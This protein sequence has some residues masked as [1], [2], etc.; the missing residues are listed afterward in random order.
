MKNKCEMGFTELA[1][2]ELEGIDGGGEKWDAFCDACGDIWE[3]VKNAVSSF[4][5]G[6]CEGFNK[7]N[8]MNF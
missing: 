7:T 4:Y 6:F 3:G 5:E 8:I 2:N 1:L